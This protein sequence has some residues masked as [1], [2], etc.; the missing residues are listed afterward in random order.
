MRSHILSLVERYLGRGHFS[1][2]E[3]VSLRCPFHKGG[4][5]TRPS[6]SINVTNGVW[7]CFSGCG[8]GSLPKLL[9][10]LGLSPQEIDSELK[11]V[12]ADLEAARAA[13]AWKKRERW[14]AQD[15][16]L[17]PTILPESLLKPYEL[18]PTRLI[19]AGFD[20]RWLQWMDI[21]FDRTNNRITYPIR[22]I[23]GNLAGISGGA[24]FSYQQP[25]YDVYQGRHEDPMTGRMIG[26][27]YGPWFDE[28]FPDYKFNNKNY[29]WNFDSVYS[30]LFF[31]SQV[32]TLIIVEG[33]KACL[34]MLQN[35]W[36]NTVALMGSSLSEVQRNLLHR[37]RANIILF[38]DNNDAGRKGSD[39]IGRAVQS[40]QPG[41]LIARYPDDAE[42]EFQP[43]DLEAVELAS[44]ITRAQP[45]PEW[46]KRVGYVYGRTASWSPEQQQ[47]R[48][49]GRR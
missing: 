4:E 19:E 20:H 43:D 32:E 42:E 16:F 46:R 10:A 5:E 8:S 37:V 18:M 41:V 26:S 15:P 30:R 39:R 40:F 44:A 34:W 11:D 49:E 21:G 1:G 35:G 24:A 22:D 36:A 3:N 45:L 7:Q 48:R 33:F 13:L 47:G 14:T 31:S 27:H 17:A 28:R 25:K 12:R 23:Y 9:K 2:E 6:F 29:L 38:L